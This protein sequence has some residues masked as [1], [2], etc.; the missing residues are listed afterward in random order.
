MSNLIQ[1]QKN[2]P[3]WQDAMKDLITDPAELFELLALDNRLLSSSKMATKSFNL[4]VPR[5]FVAKMQK[6]DMNDPLLRQILPIGEEL[7]E[8]TAYKTDPLVEIQFNPTPGLLHKYHGRVLLPVASACGINCRY[9][10]R[11]HFPYSDNN[12]AR[13]AR[14]KILRYITNDASIQEVIYSGGDP[15]VADDDYLHELTEQLFQIPHLKRLRIHSRMPIILPERIT[16]ALLDWFAADHRQTILVLHCNHPNELDIDIANAV[17]ILKQAGVTVLNQAV[18][19]HGV[20]DNAPTQ[21]ALSEAL[22][23]HGIMPYYLHLLD[24]VQGAAHFD[25]SLNKARQ[26]YQE[27]QKKLPGFLV[28]KLAREQPGVAHKVLCY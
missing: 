26:I 28:P 24:K 13:S 18:L 2:P 20:N 23:D 7:A 1:V 17:K 14:D 8:Q 16:P 9:C 19:L 22:F 5:R 25:V 3:S 4:R 10:F 12:I 6:G 21:I 27:M 15:L 11:R